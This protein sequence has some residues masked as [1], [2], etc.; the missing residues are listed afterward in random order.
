M[1]VY[2]AMSTVKTLDTESDIAYSTL[3]FSGR[4]VNKNAQT[5]CSVMTD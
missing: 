1:S 5:W 3:N 4:Y 2:D